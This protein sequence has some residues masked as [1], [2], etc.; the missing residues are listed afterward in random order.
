MGLRSLEIQ[1]VEQISPSPEQKE[2]ERVQRVLKAG[3]LQRLLERSPINPNP[4]TCSSPESAYLHDLES[5]YREVPDALTFEALEMDIHPAHRERISRVWRKLKNAQEKLFRVTRSARWI[6]ENAPS[7]ADE[8]AGAVIDDMRINVNRQYRQAVKA[9]IS[10]FSDPQS[11]EISGM[12]LPIWQDLE[13]GQ[14]TRFYYANNTYLLALR[15]YYELLLE[16]PP[17]DHDGKPVLPLDHPQRRTIVLQNRYARL[18]AATHQSIA[19]SKA[20]HHEQTKRRIRKHNLEPYWYHPLQVMLAHLV[21]TVPY[22][23][24]DEK[25][26]YSPIIG[27]VVAAMHDMSE[28]TE[29]S[30]EDVCQFVRTRLD[31]YDSSLDQVIESG[32][33][34]DRKAFK[35]KALDLAGRHMDDHLKAAL[36]VLS[37]NTKLTP[38]EIRTAFQAH[39]IPQ[40]KIFDL[41]EIPAER[42]F[43]YLK[44]MGLKPNN[45]APQSQTYQMFPEVGETE[46]DHKMDQKMT[47][48]LLRLNILAS[49]YRQQVSLIGKLE[50][51]ADNLQDLEKFP[52]ERQLSILRSTCK[53]L[54]A[55]AMLDYDPKNKRPLYNALPRLID[56]TVEQYCRIMNEYK[57]DITP[58]DEALIAQLSDWQKTVRRYKKAS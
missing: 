35:Q 11:E 1:P 36:R 39:L 6:W 26:K 54:I 43:G 13:K 15:I 56:E 21:D 40:E 42:R 12:T 38:K 57:D 23:I 34:I 25:L 32:Y 58:D 28:D 4:E 41:L 31:Q 2:E 44:G 33:G 45:K 52:I 47:A 55:W 29:L 46:L 49:G 7:T 48:F 16:K 5:N 51:R 17:E 10:R 18:L 19:L 30:V 3:Y 22:T 27:T 24:E 9:L 37:N 14:R 53:R 8:G 20:G 50:D